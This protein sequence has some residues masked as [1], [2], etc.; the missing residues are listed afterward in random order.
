[1]GGGD[2]EGEAIVVEPLGSRSRDLSQAQVWGLLKEQDGRKKK[3]RIQFA[4]GGCGGGVALSNRE[5]KNTSGKRKTPEGVR[6][7]GGVKREAQRTIET[8]VKETGTAK[9]KNGV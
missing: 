8:R 2:F 9:L 3:G 6:K 5:S 4:Y 7:F 1:V